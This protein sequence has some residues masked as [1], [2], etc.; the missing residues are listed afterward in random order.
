MIRLLSINKEE[1]NGSMKTFLLYTLAMVYGVVSASAVLDEKEPSRREAEYVKG[2]PIDYNSIENIKRFLPPSALFKDKLDSDNVISYRFTER[3][4]GYF[5]YIDK[6]FKEDR[7]EEWLY[8]THKISNFDTLYEIPPLIEMAKENIITEEGSVPAIKYMMKEGQVSTFHQILSEAQRSYWFGYAFIS[9]IG[10]NPDILDILEVQGKR[11]IMHGDDKNKY[12]RFITDLSVGFANMF[13]N[14]D[15]TVKKSVLDFVENNEVY[16]ITDWLE[17]VKYI[18]GKDDKAKAYG[19]S[20]ISSLFNNPYVSEIMKMYL[21]YKK[22]PVIVK[23]VVTSAEYRKRL[24]ADG[25]FLAESTELLFDS[26]AVTEYR[27]KLREFVDDYIESINNELTERRN[28]LYDDI[29]DGEGISIYSEV[30]DRIPGAPLKTVQEAPK[31]PERPLPE[32]PTEAEENTEEPKEEKEKKKE[33]KPKKEKKEKKQQD[34]S[35]T[36]KKK[37]EE[38][39]NWYKKF[40]K[41]GKGDK[42]KSSEKD[43]KEP[44]KTSTAPAP[45]QEEKEASKELI[46][47]ESTIEN[48]DLQRKALQSDIDK[49]QNIRKDEIAHQAEREDNTP[50]NPIIVNHNQNQNTHAIEEINKE[51]SSLL[52]G[53]INE[54]DYHTDKST[55]KHKYSDTAYDIYQASRAG[56]MQ[57]PVSSIRSGMPSRNTSRTVSP[58]SSVGHSEKDVLARPVRMKRSADTSKEQTEVLEAMEDGRIETMY[59]GKDDLSEYHWDINGSGDILLRD[60]MPIRNC[61]IFTEIESPRMIMDVQ[62]R[63]AM[64]KPTIRI[65]NEGTDSYIENEI[66]RQETDKE[67]LENILYN[68]EQKRIEEDNYSRNSSRGDLYNENTTGKR[69]LSGPE[70]RQHG[71]VPDITGYGQGPRYRQP[72]EYATIYHEAP[73][74]Y[75]TGL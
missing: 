73:G 5:T 36:P 10:K 37:D 23:A 16:V 28:S 65:N 24:L 64:N 67:L 58:V 71:S 69:Y 13:F 55:A 7:I 22:R 2:G 25:G 60:N 50:S 72:T 51:V 46:K 29:S 54:T 8:A 27:N 44:N 52:S 14:K 74:R 39:V 41:I 42:T 40:L 1:G 30:A 17:Q 63:M 31:A 38:K 57:H 6:G 19:I 26:T 61:E 21:Q 47:N 49:V 20:F 48:I 68:L 18:F 59:P 66:E 62:K 33:K 75:F 9:A 3:H 45:S 12:F 4:L 56:N 53:N 34:N 32:I 15:S 70:R 35:D 11:V 43:K